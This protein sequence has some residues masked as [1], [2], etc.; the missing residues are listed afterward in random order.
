MHAY[1]KEIHMYK[2]V[3][4]GLHPDNFSNLTNWALPDNKDR[5]VDIG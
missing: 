5:R 4:N 1:R 3:I 2:L